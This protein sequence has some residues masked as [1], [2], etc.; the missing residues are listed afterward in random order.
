MSA[1]ASLALKNSVDR[2]K[3]SSTEAHKRIP[4][5]YGLWMEIFKSNMFKLH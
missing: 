5:H 4:T 1:I 2:T 3:D